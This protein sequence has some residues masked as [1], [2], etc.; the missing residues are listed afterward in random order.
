MTL[1]LPSQTKAPPCGAADAL[2]NL[3]NLVQSTMNLPIAERTWGKPTTWS[4]KIG[5]V[6]TSGGNGEGPKV[7]Y[8]QGRVIKLLSQLIALAAIIVVL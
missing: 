3:S 6:V 1:I 5:E 8:A 4:A 2:C 7:G